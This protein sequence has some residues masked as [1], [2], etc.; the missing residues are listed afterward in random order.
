MRATAV[1]VVAPSAGAADCV[2]VSWLTV[3]VAETI[4]AIVSTIIA[5]AG[6]SAVV[7]A[8]V[9]TAAAAGVAAIS[10][11]VAELAPVESCRCATNAASTDSAISSGVLAAIG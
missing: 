8:P 3:I 4:S 10:V 5:V 11:L 2:A 9:A 1:I 6:V 7:A